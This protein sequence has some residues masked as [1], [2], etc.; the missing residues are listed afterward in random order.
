MFPPGVPRARHSTPGTLFVATDA[1]LIITPSNGKR[2]TKKKRRE[3]ER[4]ER[5]SEVVG[6]F[7]V[8]RRGTSEN[9]RVES[10]RV[11]DEERGKTVANFLYDFTLRGAGQ[12]LIINV[13]DL[14]RPV[15]L[16]PLTSRRAGA[17]RSKYPAR[18]RWRVTNYRS[19]KGGRP[20]SLE[21]LKRFC[22]SRNR[23]RP[24]SAITRDSS[25]SAFSLVFTSASRSTQSLLPIYISPFS[26]QT[27][28]D[29]LWI[30]I[31]L[32]VWSILAPE[33]RHLQYSFSWCQTL[34]ILINT[35]D[36]Y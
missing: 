14:R 8:L 29:C 5:W 11:A 35:L 17:T 20:Y 22:V 27:N 15:Y 13:G 18:T 34:W 19:R 7:Q 33:N 3:R 30:D 36:F 10:T 32:L 16:W 6:T 21:F 31:S 28:V 26:M 24:P 12:E 1:A 2:A 4:V 9:L 23:L 25:H